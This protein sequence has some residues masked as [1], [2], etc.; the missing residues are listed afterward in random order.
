MAPATRNPGL[1]RRRLNLSHVQ[2]R[3]DQL[4]R[5]LW[6]RQTDSGAQVLCW[7]CRL[8]GID[9]HLDPWDCHIGEDTRAP[10]CPSCHG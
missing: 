2:E 4:L 3:S 6:Q 7:N 8:R 9:T 5:E 10:E 1:I